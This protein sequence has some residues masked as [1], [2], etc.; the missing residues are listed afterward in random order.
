MTEP[1]LA[2]FFGIYKFD[3]PCLYI[4]Y[5]VGLVANLF[6]LQLTSA[7]LQ[8]TNH[9]SNLEQSHPSTLVVTVICLPIS[10]PTD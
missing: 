1:K 9:P 10:D 8:L 6:I 5:A 3:F 7:A 4:V 2:L